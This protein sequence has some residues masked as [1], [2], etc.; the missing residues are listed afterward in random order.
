MWNV[1][2][3]DDDS[4]SCKTAKEMH[5]ALMQLSADGIAVARDGTVLMANPALCDMVGEDPV[6]RE[7][8]ALLNRVPGP[9]S[10]GPVATQKGELRTVRGTKIP[11]EYSFAEV[12][13]EGSPARVYVIRDMSQQIAMEREAQLSAIRYNEI[14]IHSPVAFF[15]VSPRGI[16]TDINVAALELL[17]YERE[18]L[19]R[20][21]IVAIF[22]RTKEGRR[23][24]EDLITSAARGNVV[25][26]VE[27]QF[28]RS[29]GE[30]VWV[31]VTAYPIKMKENIDVIMVMA[32]DIHRRRIAEERAKMERD[33]ANLY[34]EI[35]THDLNNIN[36]E[37]V[38]SLDLVGE[39]VEIP[40]ELKVRLDQT[41]WNIRRGARMI[42]NMRSLLRLQTEPP[43]NGPFDLREPIRDAVRAVQSDM[44]WK[45]V[46]VNE[47]IPDREILIEGN[48]YLYDVFFNVVHNAAF[49][50]VSEDVVVDIR[51]EEQD[52]TVRVIVEDRGPGIPDHLKAAVFRRTDE[53]ARKITG[54]GLGLTLIHQIMKTI[55]GR[56]WIEDRVP[57]DHR[58]GTRVV[59]EFAKWVE[60]VVL[61]CGR[62]T[63]ITFYKSAHCLFCEPSFQILTSV[64]DEFGV[65]RDH[66]EEVDIDDPTAEVGDIDLS[67][68]PVVRICN[69]TL[70][71]F[72]SE[73]NVRSAVA[74]L[75]A[76]PCFP[77][78]R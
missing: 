14:L 63:C 30:L 7:I 78:N 60:P 25:A 9:D 38:F 11:V 28:R 45:R 5:L 75:F 56:V 49:F 77:Q 72:F 74:N 33:R 59:L 27:T 15:T 4:L 22:P 52:G 39:Y 67:M 12:T 76:Q 64:M 21:N 17:G 61:P 41:R 3:G 66:L 13:F 48:E 58:K 16:I 42:R 10:R 20:R 19:V 55:R 62:K 53:D 51:V 2:T 44:T 31:S 69:N 43:K 24:G 65:S 34:L 6:G 68:M 46:Q 26:N 57:G 40:D 23:A 71:G 1:T 37:V 29:D 8:S 73:D 36:Q 35:M 50:D 18:Q 70:Y 47:E 32:M 54:R